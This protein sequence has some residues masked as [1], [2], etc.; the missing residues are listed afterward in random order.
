MFRRIRHH[1]LLLWATIARC[2]HAVTERDQPV[3]V[4]SCFRAN[5][6]IIARFRHS[7]LLPAEIRVIM[8]TIVTRRS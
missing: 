7:A 6:G 4:A 1:A 2:I 8:T 5:R 3:S